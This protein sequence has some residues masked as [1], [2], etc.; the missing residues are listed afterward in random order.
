EDLPDAFFV[1]ADWKA[2]EVVSALTH[3]GIRVP[4]DVGVIGYGDI[5]DLQGCVPRL[6]TVRLPRR[7][8]GQAVG[9]QLLAWMRDR[10]PLHSQ[11]LDA[12]LGVRDSTASVKASAASKPGL[13]NTVR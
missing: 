11:M 9:R 12:K 8:I 3:A 6:T 13:S 10:T 1:D 5:P 2:M 7:E 4:E